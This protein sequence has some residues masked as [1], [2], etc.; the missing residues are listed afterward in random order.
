ML[1]CIIPP[2][3]RLISEILKELER[4]H[5]PSDLVKKAYHEK[6]QSSLEHAKIGQAWPFWIVISSMVLCTISPNFRLIAEILKQPKRLCRLGR[7][8]RRTDER[9]DRSV[10]GAAWSQLKTYLVHLQDPKMKVKA[11]LNNFYNYISSPCSPYVPIK[12]TN[13]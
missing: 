10:L 11:V 8:Y 1:L 5:R 2:I 12:C 7:T 6:F 3:F 9:M 13:S 4:Q